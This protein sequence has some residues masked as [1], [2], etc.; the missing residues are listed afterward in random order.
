MKQ[1]VLKLMLLL[2][3]CLLGGVS[4]WAADETIDFTAQGYTNQQTISSY[5]GTNCTITFEKGSN[6]NAPKYYTAGTAIRAYG[7]NTITISSTTKTIAAVTFTFGSSDG[8]NAIT[9]ASG[10]WSSPDWSGSASSIT[11]TI[12]GSSGHRRIAGIAVTYESGTETTTTIDASAVSTSWSGSDVAAGTF[13][14]T[15]TPDGESALADPTIA[16]T[17]SNTSVAEINASTGAVTLKGA[18]TTTIKATYAGVAGAYGS[19]SATYDLVVTDS[20]INTTTTIDA[21]G[22]T[23][24]N[25]TNG[26]AAGSLTATVTE[27]E[28]GDAVSGATVTWTSSNTSVATITAGVVTLVGAGKTT[29]TASYE[30]IAGYS[31]SS[32][33]YVLTVATDEYVHDIINSALTGIS[34]QSYSDISGMQ[35]NSNAVYGANCAGESNTVQLRSNNNN[36]GIVTTTTGGYVRKVTIEWSTKTADARSLQVYGD[37]TAYTAATQLYGTP[38]GTLLGTLSKSNG[39]TELTIT[40]DYAYIA[41]RSESGALYLDEIDIAWETTYTRNVTSGE[42]GTLCLPFSVTGITG[43]DVYSIAGV[44]KSGDDIVGVSLEEVTGT[45]VAGTPYI[46]KATNNKIEATYGTDYVTAAVPATGLVGNLSATPVN[47][48]VDGNCGIVYGTKI[49]L[50]AEN[51]TATAGQNRAYINLKDVD[52]AGASVKGIRLY[53]DGTEE[54]T[55][56]NGLTPAINEGNGAIYNLNG[57]RME[58]L[59]KGIN[60]VNGKKVIIK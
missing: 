12:S 15:V 42:Y 52:V 37:N 21:S 47:V 13:T 2:C 35:D 19:S 5:T 25:I 7:G 16:W 34:T 28:S 26:T 3:T 32:D 40:G 24:T 41:V 14:A 20:R 53:F 11:F 6:S 27:T 31:P 18:G 38:K 22:I 60:I 43:A 17:S 46:F 33:T 44:I 50:L 59:Q 36:S 30:G 56:I 8:S 57:Q 54:S 48:S 49:L 29:I 45:L 51:A 1:K 4:A 58:T 39:D 55:G 9:A 23:N 10:T